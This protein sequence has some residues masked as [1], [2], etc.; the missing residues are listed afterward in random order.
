[1]FLCGILFYWKIGRMLEIIWTVFIQ[2]KT[3]LSLDFLFSINDFSKVKTKYTPF[4]TDRWLCILFIA[5]VWFEFTILNPISEQLSEERFLLFDR[6][7]LPVCRS[8]RCNEKKR[9][10][11]PS[12][13][14]KH[15]NMASANEQCK[16]SALCV[17]LCDFVCVCASKWR[18]KMLSCDLNA[19]TYVINCV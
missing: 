2:P 9:R 5:I 13:N 8:T 10:W 3:V 12:T 11:M 7:C 4:H 14:G 18:I 6:K 19:E 1:M 16:I 15:E 17:I